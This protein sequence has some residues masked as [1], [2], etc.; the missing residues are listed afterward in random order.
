MRRVLGIFFCVFAAVCLS[1]IICPAYW[2]VWPSWTLGWALGGGSLWVG[3]MLLLGP[4]D[5]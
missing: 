1:T 4:P 3:L 2:R 5:G